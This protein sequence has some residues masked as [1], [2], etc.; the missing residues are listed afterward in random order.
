MARSYLIRRVLPSD[1]LD[2]E[3]DKHMQ[4]LFIFACEKVELEER[5]TS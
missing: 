3:V 1:I 5:E 2:Y 4:K